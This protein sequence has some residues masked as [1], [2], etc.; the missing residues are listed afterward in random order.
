MSSFKALAQSRVGWAGQRHLSEMWAQEESESFVKKLWGENITFLCGR[1]THITMLATALRTN[2]LPKSVLWAMVLLSFILYSPSPILRMQTDQIMKR[3]WFCDSVMFL[4]LNKR[5]KILIDKILA[6]TP[7]KMIVLPGSQILPNYPESNSIFI[8][9]I[10]FSIITSF[11]VSHQLWLEKALL[12]QSMKPQDLM[13][14][15]C[16]ALWHCTV[17]YHRSEQ[18]MRGSIGAGSC[19]GSNFWVTLRA[20]C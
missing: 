13:N 18:A 20:G 9:S 2:F 11:F 8:R 17:L 12:L 10:F 15:H 3:M 4:W 19:V 1:G 6:W 7:L 5:P 14:H 16:S